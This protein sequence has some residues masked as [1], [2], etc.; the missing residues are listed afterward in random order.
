MSTYWSQVEFFHIHLLANLLSMF[1]KDQVLGGLGAEENR[2][3]L[4]GLQGILFY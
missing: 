1:N 3:W 4:R 2:A